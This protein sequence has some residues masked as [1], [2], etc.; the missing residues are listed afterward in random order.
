MINQYINDINAALTAK[1]GNFCALINGIAQPVYIVDEEEETQLPALIEKGEDATV[2]IDDDY[3]FGLYH[4]Q[5][6]SNFLEDFTKGFGDNK[7]IQ[8]V[9]DLSVIAWGFENKLTAEELKDYFVAV[10]PSFVRFVSV[11]FD[12]K[13]IFN[14]EFKNVDFMVDERIFLMQ[15]NYKVQYDVKKSCLE[16]N[17]N[18][19]I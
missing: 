5:R 3:D 11:S 19:N 8:E 17:S 6:G 15:I 18:F 9:Q 7:R 14:Q 4:K 10:S 16:I 1:L 13:T 2:F 12:K